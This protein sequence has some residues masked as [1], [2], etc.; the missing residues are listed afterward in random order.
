MKRE[1]LIVMLEVRDFSHVRFTN[2]CNHVIILLNNRKE[3]CKMG[4]IIVRIRNL[5]IK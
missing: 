3:S 4:V 5:V 2:M 1:L